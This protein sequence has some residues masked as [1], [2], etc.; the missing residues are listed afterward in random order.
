VSCFRLLNNRHDGGMIK[1][2]CGHVL[3]HQYQ[4]VQRG[5]IR[6]VALQLVD[7]GKPLIWIVLV[8]PRGRRR[9]TAHPNHCVRIALFVFLTGSCRPADRL[10]VSDEQLQVPSGL[11]C[12]YERCFESRTVADTLADPLPVDSTR[13]YRAAKGA[14]SIA[15]HARA[16]IHAFVA[17]P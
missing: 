1:L 7:N 8:E 2:I 9:E 4:S 11:I 10:F 12:R 16:Y 15:R 3:A 5:P 17:V 13:S 6:P 14:D